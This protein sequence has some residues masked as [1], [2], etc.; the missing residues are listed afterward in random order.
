M[1]LRVLHVARIVKYSMPGRD[2]QLNT[3]SLS[4]PRSAAAG[5]SD[6]SGKGGPEFELVRTPTP[7]GGRIVLELM[8][9]HTSNEVVR[10]E[11]THIISQLDGIRHLN[12]SSSAL[13][14]ESRAT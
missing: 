6:A 3:G 8:T 1:R 5:V 4:R 2:L 10:L 14:P 13:S 12:S 11:L 7:G 9:R